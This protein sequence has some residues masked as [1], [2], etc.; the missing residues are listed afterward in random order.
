[1]KQIHKK[2]NTDNIVKLVASKLEELKAT[3]I[4]VFDLKEKSLLFDNAIIATGSSSRHVVTIADKLAD[5]LKQE[6]DTFSKSEGYQV[7][8]WILIDAGNVAINIFQEEARNRYKLEEIWNN[9]EPQ[10]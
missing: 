6:C 8:E 4:K 7:G 2:N 10:G 9:N 1:M 5:L 3:D